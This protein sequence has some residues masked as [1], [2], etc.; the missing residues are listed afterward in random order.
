[1]D[2]AD[3]PPFDRNATTVTY[4]RWHGQRRLDRD[5]KAAAYPLGFGLSYTSFAITDVDVA[6]PA[7]TP[8]RAPALQVRAT[9]ENTG[10][11]PGGHVVQVYARRPS[12]PEGP[13]R[14]LIGFARAEVGAGER[15]PV[16]IEIPLR[17]LATR[18]G[19]GRWVVPAGGYGIDVG[20]NAADP[21]AVS[22]TVELPEREV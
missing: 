9:V 12:G 13:E 22:V 11:R 19:P 20:A 4:D 8:D 1:V 21:A 3:L 2:A 16:L 6:V 14:Y 18:V 7:G 17:R 10:D 5:G 15:A